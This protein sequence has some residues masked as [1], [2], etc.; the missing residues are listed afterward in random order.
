MNEEVSMLLSNDLLLSKENEIYEILVLHRFQR[1]HLRHHQDPNHFS[2]LPGID[3]EDPNA[4]TMTM[5]NV[6][7]MKMMRT[8]DYLS[9]FFVILL[10]F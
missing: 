2:L 4:M 1:Y 7:K 5:R 3:S 9:A 6:M 8:I 10:R